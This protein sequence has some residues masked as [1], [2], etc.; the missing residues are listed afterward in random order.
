MNTYY[1]TTYLVQHTTS[2][3]VAIL[4]VDSDGS[5]IAELCDI[6]QADVPTLAAAIESGDDCHMSDNDRT[7]DVPTP[8]DWADWRIIAQSPPP[9]WG[10]DPIYDDNGYTIAVPHQYPATAIPGPLTEEESHDYNTTYFVDSAAA[11][12]ALYTKIKAT[13]PHQYPRILAIIDERRESR[14]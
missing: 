4:V 12:E 8:I 5:T 2:G 6:R 14:R 9:H 10:N 3:E 11:E 7:L 13:R 1:T